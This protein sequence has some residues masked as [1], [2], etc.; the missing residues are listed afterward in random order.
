MGEKVKILFLASNPKDSRHLRLEEEAKLIDEAIQRSGAQDS[1]SFHNKGAVTALDLRRAMLDIK[2]NIVHF[3]GHGSD[4]DELFFEDADGY[5]KA[6]SSDDLG[7]FFSLFKDHLQCVFLN[8]CYSLKQAEGI[9]KHVPIVIGMHKAIPNDSAKLFSQNFYESYCKDCTIEESFNIAKNALALENRDDALIPKMHINKE[10]IIVRD[11]TSE[12]DPPNDSLV[13][14][15]QLNFVMKRLK[16]DMKIYA[17]FALLILGFSLA[18]ALY[19]YYD[20]E[21]DYEGFSFIGCLLIS[22]ISGIPIREFLRKRNGQAFIQLLKKE[23]KKIAA[24]IQQ[25]SHQD[26]ERFNVKFENYIYDKFAK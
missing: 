14:E 19:L 9:I 3:S 11:H 5:T 10:E 25:L 6:I 16:G 2:P 7:Q 8:A 1:F 18:V 20:N 24:T 4:Q 17:G 22:L 15:E 12:T 23:R 21:S 13:T 26:I